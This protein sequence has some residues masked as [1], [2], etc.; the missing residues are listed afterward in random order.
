MPPAPPNRPNPLPYH[1]HAYDFPQSQPW[2]PSP[3]QSQHN[4]TRFYSMVEDLN[5]LLA[6][7]LNNGVPNIALTAV[8][9]LTAGNRET[10]MLSFGANGL[11][12]PKVVITGGIHA[13]EWIATEI[14]YLIAEYLIKNYPSPAAITGGLT[15]YQAQLKTLVDNRNIHIIPMINPDGNDRTVFGT[16]AGARMWRKNLRPLPSSGPGWMNALMPLGPLAPPT[17]PFNNVQIDMVSQQTRYEVPDYGPP[18]IPPGGPANYRLHQLPNGRTGVD[19]NRNMA[20]AAWAYD[21]TTSYSNWDPAKDSYFGT[22]AGSEPESGNLQ[23]AMAAVA[24]ASG[25]IAV[26]IDYHSPFQQIL[27][28]GETASGGLTNLRKGIGQMLLALIKDRWGNPYQLGFPLAMTK[29]DAT[30]TVSD[31]A[32]QV[33]QANAFTIELDSSGSAGLQAFALPEA[34]IQAV[35]EGNIRGALAAITAPTTPLLAATYASVYASWKV[36]NRGN[37]VP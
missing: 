18:L 2:T 36:K 13:R 10:L 20:T 5:G 15:L 25:K 37:R 7:G 27:Y 34:K 28:P 26:A 33:H 35:F 6:Y 32:A 23:Q 17:P 4:N 1:F 3:A 19:L 29:Y 24:G 22:D 9:G 31:R 30:G 8:G 14:A 11:N 16:M 21:C 12:A